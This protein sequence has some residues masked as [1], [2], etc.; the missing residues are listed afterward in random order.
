MKT[1]KLSIVIATYNSAETL[2][3]C[4]DSIESQTF[5]DL[6]V[7]VIDGQSSDKTVEII[8][9]YNGLIS[10]WHSK[11]DRGIYDAWNQGVET[12]HGEYICFIGSDDFYTDNGSLKRIFDAIDERQFDLVSSKGILA[13]SGREYLFGSTW[14]YRK[15]ARRIT[16]C[17]PG[18]M[19]HRSLFEKYGKFDI[20]YRI[21]GDY[22]FLLRLP[23]ETTSLHVDAV[24]V[25]VADGG[26]SRLRY[27]DMLREK[28]KAQA[29]CARIGAFRAWL[30]YFDKLWRI[31][32]ARAL[33]IPY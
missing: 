31:P 22:E 19:H 9:Q 21:V 12:A 16:V 4:L 11:K 29:A 25:R 17:H 33:R 10:Y 28:R 6:E 24:T 27:M 1:P 2:E 30:N 15:I 14:S 23:E 18:L 7:I 3:N 26:I 13:G 20:N 8:K 32:I 5:R